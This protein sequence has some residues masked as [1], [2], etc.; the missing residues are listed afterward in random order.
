MHFLVDGLFC[1]SD[2]TDRLFYASSNDDLYHCKYDGDSVA[3]VCIPVVYGPGF[4]A[5]S[6][7]H[8]MAHIC[9]SMLRGTPDKLMIDNHG[10]RFDVGEYNPVSAKKLNKFLHNEL[11]VIAIEFR[12]AEM[13][14]YSVDQRDD[15]LRE[16]MS[17]LKSTDAFMPIQDWT[18]V[19]ASVDQYLQEYTSEAVMDAWR[20]AVDYLYDRSI[21]AQNA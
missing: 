19:P 9:Y 10:M 18:A 3:S 17:S 5:E 21:Y 4:N 11:R 13:L 7:L 14:G 1:I 8:E 15:E 6:L 12:M 2:K 16:I 20:A